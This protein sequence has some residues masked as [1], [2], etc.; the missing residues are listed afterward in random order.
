MSKAF[1]E[2]NPTHGETAVSWQ[3]WSDGL[4]GVPTITGD[5]DWGKLNLDLTGEEGRSTVYDLGSATSRK[6]TLTENRYGSGAESATLQIRGDASSFTQD[7]NLLDWEDYV[8]PISRTWRYI[9]VR[10]T[11]LNYYYVDWT[12]G[13]DAHTGLSPAQAWKTC[14]KVNATSFSGGDHILFKRGETGWVGAGVELRLNYDGSAGHYIVYGSYGSGALPQIFLLYTTIGIHRSY[15]IV[16]DIIFNPNGGFV[17]AGQISLHDSILYNCS[18]INSTNYGLT[19][20]ND[21]DDSYNVTVSHCFAYNNGQSGL[22]ANSTASYIDFEYCQSHDNGTDETGDHG[23]YCRGT[24]HHIHHNICYN[25]KAAGIKI[26][27]ASDCLA[28]NNYCYDN[29]MGMILTGGGG[30]GP[31]ALRNTIRNNI[32]YSNTLYGIHFLADFDDGFVYN[33]TIANNGGATYGHQIYFQITGADNTILKNNLIYCDNAICPNVLVR[34]NA[35]VDRTANVFDHNLY[36]LKNGGANLFTT[37]GVGSYTWAQWQALGEDANGVHADP[38]FV[39]N[40]SD[41]HIQVTSLAR[42]AGESG[43]GVDVDFDDVVRGSP[44]DIG[45]YQ[46]V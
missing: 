35:A 26:N 39:T 5:P 29:N 16:E 14:T 23:I 2:Q 44:P 1:G 40:Y 11:T 12:G 37:D 4:G 10:E 18:F 17:R 45:A 15:V 34:F 22:Y 43:L 21:E 28:E 36:Y 20:G 9:Q 27:E 8:G 38:V 19:I 25:N 6:F 30:E 32:L 41:L 24:Y 42:G 33:N 46:Y 31:E 7:S 13:N 3:T